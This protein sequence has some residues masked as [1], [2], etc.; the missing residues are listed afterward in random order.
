VERHDA[1]GVVVGP[2]RR[3]QE[4]ERA[5]AEAAAKAEAKRAEAVRKATADAQTIVAIRNARQAG[6]RALW[7]YPT[8]GAG[9][10]RRTFFCPSCGQ[11][12]L[13]DGAAAAA[14]L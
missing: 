11:R 4:R 10:P 6:G 14:K 5:A 1:A 2:N 13:R 7:F 8:I 12:N 3:A 9:L